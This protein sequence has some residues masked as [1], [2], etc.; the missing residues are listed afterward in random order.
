MDN[1]LKFYNEIYETLYKKHNYGGIC[2][3]LLNDSHYPGMFRYC[4]NP[5][6]IKFHSVLDIG[7]GPGIGLNYMAKDL[8]KLVC[9]IDPSRTAID[10][11]KR[12]GYKGKVASATNIPYED[13]SFDL[14]MSTEVI[15][16][17]LPSDQE[18][19]HRECFRVSNRYI[20]HGISNTPEGYRPN[21]KQNLHLT[22][23]KHDQWLEFFNDLNLNWNLIYYITPYIYNKIL[24]KKRR[25]DPAVRAR[26]GGKRDG[27][28]RILGEDENYKNWIHHNTMVVFEKV[29]D[30]K[31]RQNYLY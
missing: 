20:A 8:G 26:E 2:T 18:E 5:S 11:V 27:D 3:N 24:G 9:G 13:N 17:L 19:A 23:W 10:K 4:I 21:K 7:C 1:K 30:I 6:K 22:C 16:H 15:E 28:A 14:V 25:Y 29:V 12:K 31:E